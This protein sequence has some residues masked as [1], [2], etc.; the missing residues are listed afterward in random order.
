MLKETCCHINKAKERTKCILRQF[1]I[2][3]E[4]MA[5][6]LMKIHHLPECVQGTYPLRDLHGNKRI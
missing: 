1:V 4:A 2:A 3:I 5:F 6:V